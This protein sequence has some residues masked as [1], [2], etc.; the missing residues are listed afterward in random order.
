METRSLVKGGFLFL[1]LSIL[2]LAVGSLD[3]H[4]PVVAGEGSNLAWL[5]EESLE[6]RE[7]EKRRNAPLAA[8]EAVDP[9]R[10]TEEELDR[11]PGIGPSTAKAWVKTR[12]Q[13]GGF[14]K[15]EDLLKVPGVGPATLEKVTPHL[16]FSDGVQISAPDRRRDGDLDRAQTMDHRRQGTALGGGAPPE[17]PMRI[18]LNRASP[19]DL[20]SL[21]GIGPALAERIVENRRKEG[22]FLKPEDLLRV[23][24][25][26]PATL[27]RVRELIL[28]RG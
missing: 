18:D 9:N 4:A 10:S 1:V 6:A 14:W 7:E 24:G 2:R 28:P 25:I 22:F 20:E 19:A 5:L 26:G 11:L 23:R 16:D 8:G 12:E 15:A 13:E 17:R 3:P 21:P 27:G